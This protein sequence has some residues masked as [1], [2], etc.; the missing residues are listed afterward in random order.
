M[1]D[2]GGRKR[3]GG[4]GLEKK[5]MY[6]IIDCIILVFF[7]FFL[8]VFIG[9]MGKFVKEKKLKRKG[10][11]EKRGLEEFGKYFVLNCSYIFIMLV[12]YMLLRVGK[13]VRKINIIC[14]N[15]ML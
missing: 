1:G 3:K 10:E 12:Y 4:E 2:R 5:R 7:F 8:G 9:G 6:N 14:K 15:F 11:R 13:E